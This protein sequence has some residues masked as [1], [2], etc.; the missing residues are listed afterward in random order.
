M[1]TIMIMM[2]IF[3]YVPCVV[4]IG[5]VIYVYGFK[6]R[7]FK[8]RKDAG[9]FFPFFFENDCLVLNT[10][11]PTPIPFVNID[12]IE[13]HYNQWE[14]D[15]QLSYRLWVRVVM[16]NGKTKKIYYKGYGTGKYPYPVDMKAVLEEKGLRVELHM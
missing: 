6:R 3:T 2:K 4:A 9:A 11:L 13:L 16:K 5:V 1:N 7:K 14:L 10:G 12:H 8:N 15:H